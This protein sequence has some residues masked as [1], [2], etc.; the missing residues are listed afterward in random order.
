[1]TCYQSHIAFILSHPVTIFSF[2]HLVVVFITGSLTSSECL[3][4]KTVLELTFKFSLNYATHYLFNNY[5]SS[6]NGPKAEWAIDLEPMR[7]R[8]IIVLVKS[9]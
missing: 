3:F 4:F 6:P 5:S 1:M 9:N 7:A 8:G 2:G